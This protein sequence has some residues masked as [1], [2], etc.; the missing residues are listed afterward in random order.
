MVLFGPDVRRLPR[1]RTGAAGLTCFLLP[2][3]LPDGARN[4]FQLMRLKDKLGDWSNASSEVEFQGAGRSASA[5]KA[6]ASRHPRHGHA[7][8]AGLHAG[9]RRGMRMALAQAVHHARH[10]SAFG[11]HLVDQPL[12]RN[13][14]ADLGDRSGEPRSVVDARRAGRGCR[15]AR[16]DGSGVRAH[17]HCDRQVLD[18]QAR[19]GLRQRGAGVPGRG[20]VRRGVDVAA[21]VSAGAAQFDLGR[22]REHPMLDVLRAL[23]R[24]PES[25]AA[26]LGELERR[27]G[28][29]HRTTTHSRACA[30]GMHAP[31]EAGARL[32]VETDGAAVAGVVVVACGQP[33]RRRC[34]A[35][36]AWPASTAWRSGL[37][38]S[39]RPSGAWIE[40]V[41]P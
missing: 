20:G 24:E 30:D 11:K 7:D 36:A 19:A 40:R 25:G 15:A 28:W 2:R 6:A 33:C 14:L 22:Q 18:L 35:A 41:L 16:P 26:L 1:A 8:A 37:F 4:A 39:M 23:Q 38:R 9:V 5:T 21:A 3:R 27:A 29:M 34:S 12:M 31:G 17:R 13:V 10:R 32:L